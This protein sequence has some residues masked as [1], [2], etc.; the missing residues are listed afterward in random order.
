MQEKVHGLG[1]DAPPISLQLDGLTVVGALDGMGG[2]GGTECDSA[3]GTHT[4]A[5]VASR[6]VGQRISEFIQ[7][8][9]LSVQQEDFSARLH[10]VVK[11][12]L[13]QELTNYPPKS[14]LGL[15]STLIKTYPTTLALAC[16]SLSDE[17]YLVDI[18]WA[19]DSRCYLWSREGLFQLTQDDLKGGLD[20]LQNLREDAPMSNCLQ[21]ESD[22]EIHHLRLSPLALNEKFVVFAATDGCFGYYASPMDFEKAMVDALKCS[23]LEKEWRSRLSKAFAEATGDDFS[24]S[25][26]ALGFKDFNDIKREL[27]Q[28]RPS[29][30]SYFRKRTDYD[31]CK[32]SILKLKKKLEQQGR[33]LEKDIDVLWEKYKDNYQKYLKQR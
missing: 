29:L 21:A 19:G 5:Y 20:P 26:V 10:D 24:F 7:H 15:R 2:A 8:N 14:K 3:F 22:F 31:K 6:I 27:G 17:G 1:E 18:Y 33:D 13:Q 9:P 12:R 23:S 4:Q 25:L 11:E 32:R 30:S 28:Y 16:V